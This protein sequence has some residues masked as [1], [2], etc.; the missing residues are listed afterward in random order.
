MPANSL[1]TEKPMTLTA[2]LRCAS[3][4]A[5]GLLAV[6]SALAGQVQY[7]HGDPTPLEQQALELINRARSNP[8]QE[9]VILDSVNTWYSVDART[10]K[11]AFFTN[12]R[13]QLA[14]FPVVPPLA[15][16]PKLI[17]AARAH[18]QD[19]VARNY[20]AHVN[21]EGM[22]PTARGAAQGYDVGVGENIDGGGASVLADIFQSHFGF[23]VEYDNV[24]TTH[25]YG[26]RENILSGS[27]TEIGVGV[28]GSRQGGRITQD[29]GGPARTYILGVA[30]NDANS[31]GSYDAG[32]GIAGITVTPGTGNWFAIT[33]TSGGFAIPIDPVQTITDTI[34][35]P[36]NV[37]G[38]TWASVLPYDTAYRQQ[39]I[40]AAPNVT[41]NL[42]WS[43]GPLTSPRSTSVTMKRP[44]LINYRIV[45]TDG[46]YYSMS[47]VTSQSV[48]ADLAG[49]TAGTGGTGGGAGGGTTQQTGGS[50]RDVNGDG[51]GDLVLQNSAGQLYAWFLDGTGN[52]INFSTGSGLTPGSHYL[53]SSALGDWRLVARADLNND[54]I[55]DLIFQ[56]T[57][58]QIYVWCLD[59][60]GSTVTGNGS[61]MK[62]GV[63]PHFLYG[64][65]L[66]DWRVVGCTDM[67]GDGNADLIF[68]NSAGQIYVW[69][70]DGTANTVNFSTGAGLKPG[71]KL[72]C[73]GSLGDWRVVGCTDMNG[74]G[75]ADFVFQNSIGQ[76]VVWILDGTATTINYST[77]AGL[78]PGSKLTYSG[79]LGDWRVVACTDINGDGNPDL[80]FQNGVGQIYV[81][82]LDGTVSPINF[83]TGTGLKPGSK[84][85]YT[86][87]LGDWRVR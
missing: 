66:G 61:G 78:K 5:S 31:N 27:Y 29:F 38:A 56:N 26:H 22:D 23:M 55:P 51:K 49:T 34:T 16:H 47:M 48:K 65:A 79:G 84:L 44:A 15:F 14:A 58:G 76:I 45:G 75:I 54:G 57:A 70:L 50:P 39:Q 52:A 2:F 59:G 1:V 12:L 64:G 20:F 43:G 68:Q 4:V 10:R 11:P 74:D 86:G 73:V 81:W 3:F 80:V 19:M 37:Q 13:A 77:G 17:A 53:Y 30:Y 32:E 41:V 69:F 87:G 60:T 42:T 7:S 82:T 6:S 63:S 8:T 40:A 35:V 28:A 21:P 25:L 72:L 9:G 83:S 46:W 24:D 71:S 85:L 62:V 18:S 36:F 67:N 33:S